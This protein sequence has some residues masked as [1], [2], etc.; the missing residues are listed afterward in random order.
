MS[1]KII[2]PISLAL[3]TDAFAV[4]VAKGTRYR[5][6]SLGQA[7]KIGVLFGSFEG[8]MCALGWS[9]AALF[10]EAIRSLDHWIAL[11]LLGGVGMKMILDVVRCENDDIDESG[12][13]KHGAWWLWAFTAMGTS[14]D[15]AAIGVALAL[16]S[17][18]I[19]MAA[20][21]I[22]FVSFIASAIGFYIGPALG[23][24]FG[25]RAEFLGGVLLILIGLAIF[26]SHQFG[27][28]L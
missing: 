12:S 28:S 13:H 2:L 5:K 14:I 1:L 4:A 24:H 16:T 22:G 8:V 23:T 27:S 9:L 19:W 15:S 21:I 11:I 25:K 3:S 17:V 10:A 20:P 18:S 6:R 26:I 7:L